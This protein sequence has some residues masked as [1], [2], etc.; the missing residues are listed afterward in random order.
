MTRKPPVLSVVSV[1]SLFVS[2]FL[3]VTVAPATTSLF[4]F[5]TVPVMAPWVFDCAIALNA[6][7]ASTISAAKLKLKILR[8]SGELLR[9]SGNRF[10][11]TCAR[12]IGAEKT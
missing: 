9:E 4:G 1:A 7:N 10:G 5:L 8:I 6:Q 11:P 3:T 2:L 12:T